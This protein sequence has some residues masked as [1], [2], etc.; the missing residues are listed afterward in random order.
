METSLISKP[1]LGWK[2]LFGNVEGEELNKGPGYNNAL[3]VE[4]E[5]YTLHVI[6]SVPP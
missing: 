1:S 5:V 4:V 3:V 6:V 2:L